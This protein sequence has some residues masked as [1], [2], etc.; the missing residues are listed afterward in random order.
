VYA[1]LL[2]IITA[3]GMPAAMKLVESFGGTRIYL[4]L[5][6]NVTPDN[7]IAKVIGVE[8]TRTLARLWA[9]ERPS[10]PLARR[11]LRIIVKS[12]ILREKGKLSVPELA[13]KY[14]TTERTIFRYMSEIDEPGA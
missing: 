2:D 9:Q 4:P 13:R 10:I 3:I 5:P 14:G 7:E 8:A 6:E 11:H 1:P 12:E